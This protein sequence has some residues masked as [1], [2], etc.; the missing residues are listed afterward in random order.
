MVNEG[1]GGVND[2]FRWEQQLGTITL[3]LPRNNARSKDINIVIGKSKLNVSVNNCMLIDGKLPDEVNTNESMWTADDKEITIELI[4]LKAEWWKHAVIG[5]DSID[6]TECIPEAISYSELDSKSQMEV[7]KLMEKQR[8]E[9]IANSKSKSNINAASLPHTSSGSQ[10]THNNITETPEAIRAREIN[11]LERI[12][13][14]NPDMDF[15]EA[16]INYSNRL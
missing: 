12:K 16:C 4:K 10:K 8:I 3:Y 14:A 1:N 13:K 7:D 2:V 15:S 5:F 11:I 6:I 9:R